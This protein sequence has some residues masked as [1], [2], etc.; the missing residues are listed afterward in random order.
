MGRRGPIGW[1]MIGLSSGCVTEIPRHA[2]PPPRPGALIQSV[3][4]VIESPISGAVLVENG[5]EG[6]VVCRAPCRREVT[7]EEGARYSILAPDAQPTSQFELYSKEDP[8]VW[9]RHRPVFL[10]TT[11]GFRG[12]TIGAATVGGALVIA[13]AILSSL[14]DADAA[15]RARREALGISGLVMVLPVTTLF[16]IL[17]A[18]YSDSAVD[19]K[20][21]SLSPLAF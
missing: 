19:F 9:L 7:V 10:D 5:A 18:V 16:G 2:A 11:W 1:L 3:Q 15:A 14:P 21:P 4:V 8:I 6:G 17:T 12:A 13:A 20:D